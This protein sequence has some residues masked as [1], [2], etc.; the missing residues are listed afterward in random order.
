MN[1]VNHQAH[2]QAGLTL[3]SY[4][5]YMTLW[6]PVPALAYNRSVF[7]SSTHNLIP[8]VYQR[9]TFFVAGREKLFRLLLSVR[10][11]RGVTSDKFP[12]L[13]AF[14]HSMSITR[15]HQTGVC[16]GVEFHSKPPN[17]S[18]VKKTVLTAVVVSA[19]AE[20]W[21]FKFRSYIANVCIL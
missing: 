12:T 13:P 10:L 11:Y 14:F 21:W 19:H 8:L 2:Y 9:H 7:P 6:S 4:P 18:I 20:Y 3:L 15:L 16:Q 17:I 1:S 5:A